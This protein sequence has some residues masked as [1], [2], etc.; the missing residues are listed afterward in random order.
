MSTEV[1][2]FALVVSGRSGRSAFKGAEKNIQRW[3][4][5]PDA[6]RLQTQKSEAQPKTQPK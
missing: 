4:A 3:L 1:H 6:K 2:V 5:S